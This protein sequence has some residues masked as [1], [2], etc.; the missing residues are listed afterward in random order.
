MFSLLSSV[1]GVEVSSALQSD[2]QGQLH[3]STYNI[4]GGIHHADLHVLIHIV[5]GLCFGSDKAVG[6]DNTMKMGQDGVEVIMY[7]GDEFKVIN[8]IYTTQSL[9]G[10]ATHMFEVERNKQRYILK[11]A[12]IEECRPVSE[13]EHLKTIAGIEGVPKLICAEDIPGL[14]MGNLP[15]PPVTDCFKIVKNAL[16]FALC[17]R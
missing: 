15:A 9:I 3:T 14:S 6:Y 12:W 7:A 2:R 1:H 11:D 10:Q 13:V 5:A 16:P 4:Q 8:L 17:E